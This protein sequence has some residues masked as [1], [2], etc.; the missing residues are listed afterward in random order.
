MRDGKVSTWTLIAPDGR[1]W[2]ADSSLKVCGLEQRERIPPSVAMARILE[3]ISACPECGGPGSEATA[4]CLSCVA[5]IVR[6]EPLES[7]EARRLRASMLAD[8]ETARAI[9][10]L[11]EM[12]GEV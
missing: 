11:T 8:Y 12:H 1:T 3:C 7:M 9:E 4:V 5:K 6:G 10:V 2:T